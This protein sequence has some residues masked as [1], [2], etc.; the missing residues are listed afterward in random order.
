ML[1]APPP[2]PSSGV[3]LIAHLIYLLLTGGVRRC[4][5]KNVESFLK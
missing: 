4:R 5:E 1:E 2:Y 3:F